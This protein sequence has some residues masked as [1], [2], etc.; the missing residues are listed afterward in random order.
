MVTG[1]AAVCC[2]SSLLAADVSAGAVSAIAERG[3]QVDYPKDS[4]VGGCC[5]R[6][7]QFPRDS[8]VA[9]AVSEGP[10]DGWTVL[11]REKRRGPADLRLV[12]RIKLC[13]W[14]RGGGM[15]GQEAGAGKYLVM[16]VGE[17]ER[18]ESWPD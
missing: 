3:G 14:G 9:T 16:G 11:T 15:D 10:E 6:I 7:E 12:N 4:V 8:A 5:S 18:L 17:L 1:W 13:T 2:C